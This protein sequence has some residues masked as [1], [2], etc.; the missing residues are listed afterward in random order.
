MAISDSG[1]VVQRDI[2]T[3]DR[4]AQLVL[5]INAGMDAAGL[6]GRELGVAMAVGLCRIHGDIRMLEELGEAVAIAGIGHQADAR[7]QPRGDATHPEGFLEGRQYALG[8][9]AQLRHT[10]I[11]EQHGKLVTTEA[12]Q[13][14]T[15]LRTG[16]QAFRH[17][18]EQGVSE[19][20]AL[21]V[22]DILEA[23]QVHVHHAH[24]PP[25][26]RARASNA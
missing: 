9:A 23:V 5:Q 3:A 20:M 22:V 4:L 25:S 14:P 17:L 26:R 19:V 21:G 13:Q 12:G 6:G 10:G 16:T 24:R 1:L 8:T 18:P 7:A 15:P 2:P 11:G